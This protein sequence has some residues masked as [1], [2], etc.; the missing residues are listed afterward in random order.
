MQR[1][2]LGRRS[3]R[4]AT[5]EHVWEQKL[6]SELNSWGMKAFLIRLGH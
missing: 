1:W 6:S 3:A 5:N 4:I 2:H